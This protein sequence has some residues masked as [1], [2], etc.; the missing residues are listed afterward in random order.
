MALAALGSGVVVGM[1]AL[2]VRQ[3][4]QR[5]QPLVVAPVTVRPA[6]P[7]VKPVQ[8]AAQATLPLT[9]ATPSQADLKALLEGW[10][11][12]KAAVLAGDSSAIPLAELAR[13]AQVQRLESERNSDAALGETQ[14]IDARVSGLQVLERSPARIEIQANLTYS[15]SRLGSGGA[16]IERTASTNLTNRYV[17]ARDGQIWRL[18]AFGRAR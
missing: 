4:W 5:P 14:T 16:V 17:F 18:A 9:A 11:A 10:L 8:P 15:D 13:E 12:A 2:L 3:P 6:Q 7:P 1:I